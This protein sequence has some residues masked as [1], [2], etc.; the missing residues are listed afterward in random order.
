MGRGDERA[1]IVGRLIVKEA[2]NGFVPSN[3]IVLVSRPFLPFHRVSQSA[4]SCRRLWS[5]LFPS[6]RGRRGGARTSY[7]PALSS[8]LRHRRQANLPQTLLGPNPFRRTLAPFST[9]H[10]P[11]CVLLRYIATAPPADIHQHRRLLDLRRH[12]LLVIVLVGP[13]LSSTVTHRLASIV[14]ASRCLGRILSSPEPSMTSTTS[15]STHTTFDVH[16]RVS[17]Q[18]AT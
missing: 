15:T 13:L 7:K 18:S 11:A 12:A 4:S 9:S 1:R 8:Y 16:C 3:D 17:L 2:R 10:I 5:F 6:P 14:L